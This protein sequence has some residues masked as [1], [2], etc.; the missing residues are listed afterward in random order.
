MRYS[1]E[2]GWLCGGEMITLH[3]IHNEEKG[4][5]SDFAAKQQTKQTYIYLYRHTYNAANMK[6]TNECR[7]WWPWQW[8]WRSWLE[9]A[10]I[11]IIL[12]YVL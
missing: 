6:L 7:S 4:E 12:T 1:E 5:V 8:P 10:C 11:H 9:K 3:R 2:C